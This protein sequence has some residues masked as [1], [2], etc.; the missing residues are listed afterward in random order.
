[1]LKEWPLVAFTIAGQMAVG[2]FIIAVTPFILI[3]DLPVSDPETFMILLGAVLGLLALATL[4]SF[5]HLHHPLKAFRV[6]VNIRTSWLSREIS[7]ELAFMALVVS[8][9]ILVWAGA[10]MS[11]LRIVHISTGLAGLLFLLSM[12]KIYMLETLP[13]WHQSATPLS[14]ISTSLSL[15]ALT[16]GVIGGS[17]VFTFLA[18]LLVFADLMIGLFFAPGHGALVQREGA[19]IRPPGALSQDLHLAG[20]GLEATGLGLF[21]WA[22]LGAPDQLQDVSAL[23]IAVFGLILAGQVIRRFLFYGL[24][25]RPSR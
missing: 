21:V 13:F 22:F 20:L 9:L 18:I 6:L 24:A 23:E 3:D 15:G 12:I 7:F 1:M 16:W 5:L 14:F 11:V 25:A 19:A 2:L 10:A 17:S 8:E 4:V